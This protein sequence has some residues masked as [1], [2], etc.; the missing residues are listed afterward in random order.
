MKIIG[1][2]FAPYKVEKKATP[3]SGKTFVITGTLSKPRGY[4]KKMIEDAGGKVSSSISSKTDYL[5]AGDKAGSKLDKA[6]KLNVKII[7]ID[8]LL[9]LIES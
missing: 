9:K 8:G 1:V 5:L 3:L 4:F 6:K 7:V 2:K